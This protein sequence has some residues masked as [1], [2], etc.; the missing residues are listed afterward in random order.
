MPRNRIKK[1]RRKRFRDNQTMYQGV[2]ITLKIL[3]IQKELYFHHSKIF[4][5]NKK[6]NK[7]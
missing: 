7:P 4:F 2:T 3:K 1:N 5:K 6:E